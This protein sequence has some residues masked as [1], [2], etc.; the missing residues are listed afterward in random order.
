MDKRIWAREHESRLY[1]N[2]QKHPSQSRQN[3]LA[4]LMAG[5]HSRASLACALHAKGLHLAELLFPK[6]KY[7]ETSFYGRRIK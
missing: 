3:R 5:W 1:E 6:S 2:N 7:H 4:L